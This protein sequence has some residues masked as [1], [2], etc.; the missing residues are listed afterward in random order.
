MNDNAMPAALAL[1]TGTA[2]IL[3]PVLLLLST[4]AYITA[5]GGINDGV[6]GGT[7][8]VWS[9]ICLAIATIGICRLAEPLA[10]RAAPIVN[11]VA[12]TGWLGGVAFNVQAMYLDHAGTDLLADA[13]EGRGDGIWYAFFAFL[14]WGWMAPFGFILMGWLLWR[15]R[16]VPAWVGGLLALG[17]VLFVAGR[18]ERIDVVAVTTDVVLT[19]A[20]AAVGLRLL[21]EARRSPVLEDPAVLRAGR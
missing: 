4:V 17:G 20:L 18:P 12:L 19:V 21:Q 2:A 15:T 10:P 9:C 16:V 7:I 3:G 8:G 5:G 1:I 14:P 11:V 13:G 6:L